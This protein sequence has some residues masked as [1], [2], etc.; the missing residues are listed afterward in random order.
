MNV[1]ITG[2]SRGIGLELTKQ[3]LLRGDTVLATARDPEASKG[4]KALR[5]EFGDKLQTLAVDVTNPEGPLK[6]AAAVKGWSS[7][8]DVLINNAGILTQG[9]S[10]QDLMESFAT[11]TIAPFLVTKALLPSLKRAR[12]AR[13]VHITS[14]MGSIEDNSSGGYYAYRASKSALNMINK[15]L[16]V[17]EDWL[18]TVVV[19]PGW[20]QTDMGGAG[21]TT[22]VS[23]S[24]GGIWK[25]A[26]GLRTEDTGAFF[27]YRGKRLSW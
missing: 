18:T 6:I 4:L 14:L 10:A 23:D 12:G 24:A 9:E 27:D 26:L 11:N 21:A 5:S 22:T 2:T 16:S 13:V 15:S 17:D 1:I 19:H 7:G 20:V 3:A 25:V 8:V